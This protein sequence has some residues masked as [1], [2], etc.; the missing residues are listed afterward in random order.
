VCADGSIF[1]DRDG[2]HFGQVLQYLRNGV[3]SVAEQDAS[4][5]DI[6]MLRWL[7]REFGF[8]CIDLY[9]EQQEVAFAVGGTDANNTPKATMERYD[10]ASGVWREAISMVTG[11]V[12]FGLC[13]LGGVLYSIGGKDAGKVLL[14][15]VERYDPSLDSWNDAPPMP[16]ARAAHCAVAVSDAMYVIGG[17]ELIDGHLR[18]VRKVLK[19][20]NRTQAWSEVAPMPEPQAY[21]GVCVLESNIY[22]FGGKSRDNRDTTTVYCYDPVT[23]AWTTLAPMPEAKCFHSVCVIGGLIYVLGGQNVAASSSVHCFDPVAKS[24]S[25]VAPMST[26]R[27]ACASF[28]LNGSIYVA[29]GYDGRRH[30]ASVE[31]YDVV[32]NTWSLVGAMNQ[33]RSGF[34]A[35]AM[36][37]ETNLFESLMLKAKAAQR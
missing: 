31:R 35:H 30:V 8:Y 34:A 2:E 37:V 27:S 17:L 20:D 21:A 36:E 13:A 19:F 16:R 5:L 33:E 12:D 26:A 4:E 15:S 3:V 25:A 29:G 11:R 10:A 6:S 14:A 7:K 28:V 23:D 22:V 1:I 32:S 9:L 24:W 18:R